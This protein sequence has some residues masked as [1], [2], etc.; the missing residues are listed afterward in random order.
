MSQTYRANYPATVNEVIRERTFKPECLRALREFR[1]SKAWQGTI[2][3]RKA[4]FLALHA[5]L[6]EVYGLRTT[7]KFSQISEPEAPTGNGCYIPAHNVIVLVG[8]LSVVTYLHEFAHARGADERVAVSWSVGL[9]RRFFPRS[10]ANC[11]HAGHVLVNNRRTRPQTQPEPHGEALATAPT[12]A[13]PP[14]VGDAS[15]SANQPGDSP[16]PRRARPRR[17][18]RRP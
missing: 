9:F 4:K 17:A 3:E 8:K 10:Y 11:E 15:A 1:R 14:A 16:A 13:T 12:S 18:R 2:K 6:C 7:L 5:K